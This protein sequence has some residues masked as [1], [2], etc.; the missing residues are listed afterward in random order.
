ML[1]NGLNK[2]YSTPFTDEKEIETHVVSQA[3]TIFGNRCIYL[4][5]KRKIGKNAIKQMKGRVPNNIGQYS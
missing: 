2:Y 4:D 3:S 5:C 1:V